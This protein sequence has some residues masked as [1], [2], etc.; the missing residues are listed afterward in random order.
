[1]SQNADTLKFIK[2]VNF[3]IQRGY[4]KNYSD[5]V[6][7]LGWNLSVM[8]EVMNGK[9]N[10]PRHIIASFGNWYASQLRSDDARSQNE[11]Q[12]RVEKMLHAAWEGFIQMDLMIKTMAMTLTEIK[13]LTRN[14]QDTEPLFQK[15]DIDLLAMVKHSDF[16]AKQLNQVMQILQ[17]SKE[18][19][20]VWEI[21]REQQIDSILKNEDPEDTESDTEVQ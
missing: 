21:I 13:H 18:Q 5:L 1:M 17:E 8:S 9:K 16:Y 2:H 20:R 15:A 7:K 10:A 12:N 11:I 6:K 3:S 14:R 4:I 19:Q